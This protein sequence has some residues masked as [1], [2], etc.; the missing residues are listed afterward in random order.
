MSRFLRWT[1][2]GVACTAL[3]ATT[4]SPKGRHVNV[5]GSVGSD[6]PSWAWIVV[7]EHNDTVSGSGQMEDYEA[8]RALRSHYRGEFLWIRLDDRRYLTQDAGVLKR[9]HQV[10]DP[11]EEIGRQ[12]ATVG[13]KQAE[14][15]VQ[16][17]KV[18]AQQAKIG[19]QQ[20]ALASREVAANSDGHI[21]EGEQREFNW[22]HAELDQQMARLSVL[23]AQLSMRMQ[24]WN[25]RQQELGPR[26][27]EASERLK[28]EMKELVREAVDQGL[29]KP[30]SS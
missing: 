16:Q 3:L 1:I 2:L 26:Q 8:A 17:A 9:V 4:A 12:Q 28:G 24:P 18:G 6:D 14:I 23:M 20:A 15:G 30:I 19:S 10:L 11:V 22:R 5:E 7:R 21:S 13:Q 25:L 27:Q 29:A